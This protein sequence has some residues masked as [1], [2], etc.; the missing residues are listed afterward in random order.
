MHAESYV[1]IG[2]DGEQLGV[3]PKAEALQI[4]ESANFGFSTCSARER[5]H[6]LRELWIM[7]NSVSNNKTERA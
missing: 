2:Q 4:A 5:N 7:E 1:R 3:K 6:Q